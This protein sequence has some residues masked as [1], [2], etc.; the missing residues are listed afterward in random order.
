MKPNERS[1]LSRVSC[2]LAVA[3]LVVSA[4][5]VQESHAWNGSG[6]EGWKLLP[7]LSRL[8]TCTTAWGDA[9]AYTYCSSATVSASESARGTTRCTVNGSCSITV[10]VDDVDETFTPS[11]ETTKAARATDDLDIC[12]SVDFDTEEIEATVKTQCSD[13]ETDSSTAK[14][15]GLTIYDGNDDG[16]LD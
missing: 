4:G 15:D 5:V 9:P 12:F 16:Y 1:K 10:S 3:V 11:V 2:A 13:S 14:T 7:D 8:V 6:G